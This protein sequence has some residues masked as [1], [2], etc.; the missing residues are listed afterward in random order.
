MGVGRLAW[1]GVGEKRVAG[2]FGLVG[3]KGWRFAVVVGGVMETLAANRHKEGAVS[4]RVLK[5]GACE[6]E[7]HFCWMARVRDMGWR[8][9]KEMPLG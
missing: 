5:G 9:W 1:R 2:G 3:W 7:T 4:S 6:G 8:R